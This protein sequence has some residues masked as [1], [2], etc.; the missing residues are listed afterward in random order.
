MRATTLISCAYGELRGYRRWRIR[1]Q[2]AAN[3]K[4]DRARLERLSHDLFEGRVRDALARF[5]AYADKVR[6]H[7]GSIP[8]ADEPI[9]A[10]E[11]PV[12]TRQD[13]RELFKQQVKPPDSAY[14]HQTSGSTSL[15]VTF[16]VTRESYE[17][18]TAVT[19]RGY[20]WAG[21]EE[22]SKAFILWAGV[23]KGTPLGARVKK[24][25]HNKLQRRTFFDVFQ[26]M[27]PD[28]LARCCRVINR[29][30]P[31]TIVGYTSML[32]DLARFVRDHPDALRWRARTLVNAAEGLQPGQREMLEE[33]LVQEVFLAYGSREFM[34]VGMECGG[35]AGY[36]LYTDNVQVEVVDDE[37]V[38][39]PPGEQGRILIT[40]LRNPATPFI[41]YEIGDYGSMSP[42]EPGA[43][44]GCDL[45]FPLLKSVDGRLQ[46]VVYSADGRKL[47]GLYVTY[48]MRKFEWIEGYQIVQRE[49]GRITVRLLSREE[50][51][52]E[53]TAPV[54]AMLRSKLGE[55]MD[56][57]FER[58][59]ELERRSSGKVHLV[60]SS[61][62]EG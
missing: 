20:A 36:H 47:T 61:I 62:E 56:V 13:Q 1:R 41:R 33:R 60:I 3:A 26:R 15:P 59:A 57:Q 2:A 38:P 22:G 55:D 9:V 42:E 12:W 45:P 14:I 6:A 25:V 49:P 52:P 34:G 40:D 48:T 35:H 54:A 27:G 11:L 17:W 53:R 28:E 24:A 51:T 21:A 39:V 19:D 30:R 5:P 8:E 23:Q 16:H 31:H 50:L 18:R 44:C 7:R 58:V 43:A 29:F 4:L 10:A 46:D 32:I 37:G